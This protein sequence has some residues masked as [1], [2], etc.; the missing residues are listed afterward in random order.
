MSFPIIGAQSVWE[1]WNSAGFGSWQMWFMAPYGSWM[2]MGY[3]KNNAPV[4]KKVDIGTEDPDY[5]MISWDFGLAADTPE[6]IFLYEQHEGYPDGAVNLGCIREDTG[7]SDYFLY[8]IGRE[9]VAPDT[10]SILHRFSI[11][12]AFEQESSGLGMQL[13]YGDPASTDVIN[14]NH[15]AGIEV[16]TGGG[17]GG[18][19]FIL[20]NNW[21]SRE[22]ELRKY[23]EDWDGDE[24]G[25]TDTVTLSPYYI[26]NNS[27]GRL[28]GIAAASDGNILVFINSG[29]TASSTKVLKFNAED[30]S[31]MGQTS[32]E[33]SLTAATWAQIVKSSEV[34]LLLRGLDSNNVFSWKSA[35]FY[36][37]ATA[38]PDEN[39]SNFII[40]DNLT[41][42]ASDTAITLQ[43]VARDAFNIPVLNVPTK[44]V[45]DGE[46][47]NDPTTWTDRL[48]ALMDG[49]GDDFFDEDD[50]PLAISVEVNTDGTTGIATAYYK[51]MRNGSGTLIDTINVYCPST[52]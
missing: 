3:V 47:E 22:F 6:D 2:Y 32:W 14:I 51:P 19:I 25:P 11:E 41:S 15:L 30:L 16:I 46:D 49:A 23:E 43:Y 38:V 28:R 20:T 37:R 13:T 26:E 36:D 24:H 33:P 44:F 9:N 50:V 39:K 17:A 40:E 5:E 4:F 35:V 12:N 42:F 27:L 29:A 10:T 48:G 21:D 34:F 52:V 31:Y 18:G 1:N 7:E 8:L 45:I